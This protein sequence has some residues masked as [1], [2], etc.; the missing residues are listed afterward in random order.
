LEA[1][2]RHDPATAYA[3]MQDYMVSAWQSRR[4]PRDADQED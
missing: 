4:P 3:A 2:T 1:I